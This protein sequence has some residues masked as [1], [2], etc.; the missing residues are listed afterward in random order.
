MKQETYLRKL[1]ATEI[2]DENTVGEAKTAKKIKAELKRFW[3]K[4]A[5]E[6]IR[7]NEQGSEVLID[8]PWIAVNMDFNLKPNG[9]VKVKLLDLASRR[10]PYPPF[11]Q[12]K[13]EYTILKRKLFT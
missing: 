5:L 1:A 3:K 12:V 11:Y 10:L 4:A 2:T 9:S 8:S 7:E 6:Y 13:K